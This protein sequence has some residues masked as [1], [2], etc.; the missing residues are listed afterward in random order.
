ML[1]S[2]AYLYCCEC[3]FFSAVGFAHMLCFT[4]L[5]R[6]QIHIPCICAFVIQISNK[7]RICLC[8]CFQGAVLLILVITVVPSVSYTC[9]SEKLRKMS[10][11]SKAL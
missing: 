11:K 5:L 2:H 10:P 4:A 6:E 1:R 7:V 9:L 3:D 8:G